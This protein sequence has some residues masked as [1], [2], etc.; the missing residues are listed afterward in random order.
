M[1]FI[2]LETYSDMDIKKVSLD[3]Y[4]GHPSTRIL[5]AAYAVDD[6]PVLLWVEGEP[7]EPLL[8]LMAAH[9]CVAW[10]VA[11]ER[12]LIAH[13]WR[14]RFPIE[15]RDAMVDALYSGLPAGLKDCNR[16]PFFAGESQTSKE[17]L[18]ISKFCKPQKDGRRRT[19]ETDSEDWAKFCDYCKADVFDTRLILQW[20]TAR[21]PLPER[22]LRAWR[23]DQA[24]NQRGMPV[25]RLLT[26]RAHEEAQRLQAE[27]FDQLRALTGLENPNSPAQLLQWVK[28][29]GYPFNGLSKELVQKALNDDPSE[30]YLVDD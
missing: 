23:V 11:F 5:M 28:A 7:M 9:V 13:V 19:A 2:D 18:L 21:F 24:I 27:G 22:V 10:N 26:Y 30:D 4:A 20:I 3:R 6:G 1:L 25:D 17:S 8:R 14:L 16:T 29:R 15:W 12:T